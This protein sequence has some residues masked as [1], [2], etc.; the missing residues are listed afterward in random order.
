MLAWIEQSPESVVL[1]NIFMCV[2]ACILKRTDEIIISGRMDL[3]IHSLEKLT[4]SLEF[5]KCYPAMKI[6]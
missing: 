6:L 3:S 4:V 1:N 5:E 2:C